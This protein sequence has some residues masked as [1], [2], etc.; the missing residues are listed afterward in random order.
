MTRLG[1]AEASVLEDNDFEII[2]KL[3]PPAGYVVVRTG[4]PLAGMKHLDIGDVLKFPFAQVV[5]LPPRLLKPILAARRSETEH[6]PAQA[7]PFPAIECPTLRLASVIVSSSNAFTFAT[8]GMVRAELEQRRVV[9]VL[10]KS[11]MRTEWSIV[12]LRKRAL[13]PAMIAFVL[14]LERTHL[15]VVR[16]EELLRARWYPSTDAP[17]QRTNPALLRSQSKPRD[18]AREALTGK[19]R[20]LMERSGSD[21]PALIARTSAARS[22]TGITGSSPL[23]LTGRLRR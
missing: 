20:S 1:V 19:K 23:V 8:Q 11:W 13:S 5:S 10:Q 15:D 18:T 2:A 9:A 4:H 17:A 22:S 6:G 16:D 14:E 21:Q 7:L 12:R 3:A